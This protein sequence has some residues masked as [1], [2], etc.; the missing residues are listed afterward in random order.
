MEREVKKC[1][2]SEPFQ[3]MKKNAKYDSSQKYFSSEN[4]SDILHANKKTIKN[5]KKEVGS[6]LT[7]YES[8]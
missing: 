6:S 4:K 8:R 3:A 1:W 2:S 5:R 7:F